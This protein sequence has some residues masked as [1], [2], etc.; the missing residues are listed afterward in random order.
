MSNLSG[1]LI[2]YNKMIQL[3]PFQKRTVGAAATD[4]FGTREVAIAIVNPVP[5]LLRMLC[6]HST[7]WMYTYEVGSSPSTF[8]PKVH[9]GFRR[10]W[11][12]DDLHNFNFIFI[13]VRLL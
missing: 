10:K 7:K 8:H 6:T 5:R 2:I 1:K 12:F 13:L 4:M 11:I 3:F 9:N